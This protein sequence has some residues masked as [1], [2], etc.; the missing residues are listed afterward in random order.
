MNERRGPSASSC[1]HRL[2]SSRSFTIS[3]TCSIRNFV[4]SMPSFDDAELVDG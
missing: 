3:I 2:S 4:G 1:S